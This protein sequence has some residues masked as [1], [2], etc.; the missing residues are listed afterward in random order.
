MS[1]GPIDTRLE[2]ALDVLKAARPFVELEAKLENSGMGKPGRGDAP[3]VLARI[4][5][6][7]A[8]GWP[9]PAPL[10]PDYWETAE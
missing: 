8:E 5:A 4:D 7:L 9:E 2:E 1:S 10:P 3:N 6:C